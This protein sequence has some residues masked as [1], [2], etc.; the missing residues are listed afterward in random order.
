MYI[1]S[2]IKFMFAVC[3][4]EKI[5]TGMEITISILSINEA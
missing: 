1:V 5:D 3:F 4:K 2:M